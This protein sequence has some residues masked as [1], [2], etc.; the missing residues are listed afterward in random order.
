MIAARLQTD[1]KRQAVESH[2]PR[3]KRST[4]NCRFESV[5]SL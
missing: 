4:R 3:C 5:S 2:R 1:L